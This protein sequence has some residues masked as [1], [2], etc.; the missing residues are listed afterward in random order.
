MDFPE[1][2]VTKTA[3]QSLCTFGSNKNSPFY[4]NLSQTFLVILKLWK[5]PHR[6]SQFRPNPIERWLIAPRGKSSWN[7]RRTWSLGKETSFMVEQLPS[8]VYIETIFFR[9]PLSCVCVWDI[10]RCD[11]SAEKTSNDSNKSPPFININISAKSWAT[12]CGFCR[13]GR[14]KKKHIPKASQP[15]PA[16][17]NCC[18]DLHIS[19]MHL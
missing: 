9:L 19:C 12:I 8:T 15:L 4:A 18:S 7:L 10:E 3:N 6:H 1:C 11:I 14:R 16:L 17:I 2:D 13:K 5:Y